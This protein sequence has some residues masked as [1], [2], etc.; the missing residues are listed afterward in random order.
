[1]ICRPP[2]GLNLGISRG[3]L[4]PLAPP[5]RALTPPRWL[6]EPV[7]RLRF[8]FRRPLPEARA[9]LAELS[10]LRRVVV[11]TGRRSSPERWLR[12]HGLAG[13]VDSIMINR[14]RDVSPHFK[15][16]CV[17]ELGAAEHIDDDGRTARLLARLGP[18]RVYLRDW[19]GNRDL[20]E[21]T[22]ITRVADLREL[23]RLL[24]SN[25]A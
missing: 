7:D 2:L 13:F 9:A 22:D 19:P 20:A 6:G 4:D 24:A 21:A 8:D 16:R 17:R 23:A 1:M 15:L 10:E 12:R 3:A 14:S 25:T 18:A 5:P 11:L